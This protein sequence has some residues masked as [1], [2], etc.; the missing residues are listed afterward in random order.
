MMPNSFSIILYNPA[1][2]SLAE[3]KS[4]MMHC[5]YH[6]TNEKL[7]HLLHQYLI[8][9]HLYLGIIEDNIVALLGCQLSEHR[10]KILHLAVS[11]LYRRRGIARQLIESIDRAWIEAETDDEAVN[12]YQACG[13]T[14]EMLGE[15]YPGT[16]RYRC[17][18]SH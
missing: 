14:I 1:R 10:C 8:H 6:P 7:D 9:S 4:L 11:P 2:H 3:I 16:R 12:F 18:K 5:V 13:F 15:L 17:C